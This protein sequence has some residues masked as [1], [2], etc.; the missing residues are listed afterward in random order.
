VDRFVEEAQIGGQLQHPGIAPV[1]ELG[2]LGK[3]R[4]YFATAASRG[5]R[6]GRSSRRGGARRRS[7]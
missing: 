2:L 5:K 7:A 3:S 4:P 1:H 6:W